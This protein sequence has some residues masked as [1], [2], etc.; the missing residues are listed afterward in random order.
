MKSINRILC[1]FFMMC[2][3]QVS[4]AVTMVEL[5]QGDGSVDKMYFEG[6]KVRVDSGSEPGYM[7]I[8]VKNNKVIAVSHEERKII[9]MGSVDQAEEDAQ[10]QPLNI[11][12]VNKGKGP[13]IVGYSTKH[14]QVVVNGQKCSDEYVSKKLPKD[15]GIE[16]VLGK[17]LA[18][19]P[20]MEM[21]DGVDMDPCI[22]AEP[23][24][25]KMF[26]NYG[27]PLRSI[28]AN[29]E[30]DVE[31]VRVNRKASLPSGGFSLPKGYQRVD[32]VK[33][34]QNFQKNM[35]EMTPEGMKN[36]SPE[37]LQQMKQTLE[38]MMKKMGQPEQ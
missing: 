26:S 2:I 6:M 24:I 15:L 7:I 14:Y 23:Q 35:P 34:M 3:S 33:M 19:E 29:G 28:R 9:D 21:M 1:A 13:K 18:G 8:D 16:K 5:R 22:L 30:L 27:Y 4:L 20:D 25:S 37:Q 12:F 31:V 17:M 32:M 10:G 11:Q 36:V 38:Q